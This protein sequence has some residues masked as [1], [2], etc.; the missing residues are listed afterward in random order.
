LVCLFLGKEGKGDGPARL[1]ALLMGAIVF[2]ILD[3][4]MA[5]DFLISLRLC[6]ISKAVLAVF[7]CGVGLLELKRG[8]SIGTAP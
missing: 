8:S 6:K 3:V 2:G 4:E 7:G 5:F 1:T